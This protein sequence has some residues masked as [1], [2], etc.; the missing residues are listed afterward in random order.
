MEVGAP[1]CW[2]F[3]ACGR[4]GVMGLENNVKGSVHKPKQG[5]ISFSGIFEV[6]ATQAIYIYIYICCASF[7]RNV[8]P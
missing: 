4:Y 1:R 2:G 3:K 5:P 7:I 6:Y 8:E